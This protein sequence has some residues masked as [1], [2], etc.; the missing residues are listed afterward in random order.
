MTRVNTSLAYS[1]IP[2]NRVS[3][4]GARLYTGYL[5]RPDTEIYTH[6]QIRDIHLY[7]RTNTEYI[8]QDRILILISGRVTYIKKVGYPVLSY[9]NGINWDKHRVSTQQY[10]HC[11]QLSTGLV[12][13]IMYILFF[14]ATV[15]TSHQSKKEREKI[16]WLSDFLHEY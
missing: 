12:L 6:G 4:V 8:R 2:M 14:R 3:G 13:S 16:Y 10:Q 11:Y 1:N 7:I 5:A 9:S 15:H